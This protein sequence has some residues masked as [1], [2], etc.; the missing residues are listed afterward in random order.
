MNEIRSLQL[1]LLVLPLLIAAGCSSSEKSSE[2]TKSSTREEQIARDSTS[3]SPK[4]SVPDTSGG[5]MRRIPPPTDRPQ[6]SRDTTIAESPE[7]EPIRFGVQI[8]AYRQS[9]VAE[10]IAQLARTRFLNKV[11]SVYDA[12]N[13]VTKI[14]IGDF[15][16]KDEARRFRDLIMKQFPEDYKDAWVSEIPKK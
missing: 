15:V 7:Q 12:E 11:Y 6:G 13:S 2:E 4:I 14:L 10:Q 16:S 1:R 5:P 8:G 3:E 9:D